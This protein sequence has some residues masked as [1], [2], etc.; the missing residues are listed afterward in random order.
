MAR[1]QKQIDPKQVLRLAKLGCSQAEIGEVLGCSHDTLHRRFASVLKK[2]YA[3]LNVSLRRAQF[4]AA[5][6]GN[7][8][9][10]IWL[11]KQW[12]GQ[13]NDPPSDSKTDQI[14]A[15][16]KHFDQ[17]NER[18]KRERAEREAAKSFTVDRKLLGDE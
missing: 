5:K 6:Q 11:G 16:I 14:A 13:R 3:E 8:T 4:K 7:V 12:L 15:L 9:M 10:L 1:P 18:N 17:I 2:G